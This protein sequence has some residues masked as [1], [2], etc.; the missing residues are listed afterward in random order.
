MAIVNGKAL[1]QIAET[2]GFTYT[3]GKSGKVV[4]DHKVIARHRDRCMGEAY[5]AAVAEKKTAAGAAIAARLDYLDSRVDLVIQEAEKG[6]PLVIGDVPMLDEDGKAVY[7]RSVGEL[8]TIL[9]AVAQ[10]RANA[11]LKARL[12]G[13][14]PEA[15]DEELERLRAALESPAARRLLTQL[16]EQLA[17]QEPD[18]GPVQDWSA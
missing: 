16:D 9:H 2:F 15:Q 18:D 5:T 3:D 17:A 1:R 12:A 8:R 11:D 4:G 7:V 13:A 14:V 10:G 6:H